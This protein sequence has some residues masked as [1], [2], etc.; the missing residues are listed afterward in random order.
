[1]SDQQVQYL[2]KAS[3]VVSQLA[4]E[5]GVLAKRDLSDMHF[6]FTIK[7][8][9][10]ESPNTAEIRIYNLSDA[11]ADIIQNNFTNVTVQA[12]YQKAQYG[13]IFDGTIKQF[14]RGKERSVDTYLD[15]LAAE[16]D[17]EYN[18]STINSNVPAGTTPQEIA[19][20]VA[21]SMRL[22]IK[23]L[24]SEMGGVLP[25]GKVLWG[26]SRAHL[27]Q[28]AIWSGAS[29]SIQ[30]GAIN[31]LDLTGYLPGE[32]VVINSQSGMVGIPEQT[33]EGIKVRVLLNPNL[34]IGGLVKIN[35]KDI[36]Q[37][38]S[39]VNLTLPAGQGQLPFNVRA[40]IAFPAS[41]SADGD[42]RMYVIE[43]S[44]DTRGPEWFS[45]IICLAVD[46]TA[47]L[48]VSAYAP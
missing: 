39:Q 27:R 22:P 10:E 17:L 5:F 48:P 30:D 18:F 23:Q 36:N 28:I 44:G 42:Y 1:M 41:I 8:A 34:N 12:G 2:R 38:T 29:W 3:L 47:K 31:M 4:G 26:M 35:N 25:R 45:D 19:K 37:T 43:H 9:D 14:R 46:K 15:I 7:G 24:P 40:G 16:N 6:K 32:Q 20:K 33:D 11:T 21:A 13:V